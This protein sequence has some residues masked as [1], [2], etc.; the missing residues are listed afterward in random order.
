LE[1]FCWQACL[2]LRRLVSSRAVQ[3]GGADS[4]DDAE[5]ITK[6]S[7]EIEEDRDLVL[8]VE[9]A[10][11]PSTTY[12]EVTLT[13][14]NV[15]SSAESWWW[16]THDGTNWGTELEWQTGNG[17]AGIYKATVAVADYPD[18][19]YITGVAG[20]FT[21]KVT[22]VSDSSS[23]S[24]STDSADS[25]ST[26]SS[27]T[28]ST[29]STSTDSSSTDSS[30]SSS[31]SGTVLSTSI[32]ELWGAATQ[33]LLTADQISGYSKLTIS[34]TNNTLT[35]DTAW[36]FQLHSASFTS[37]DASNQIG[38]SWSSDTTQTVTL[39]SI[40][41]YTSGIY[42]TGTWGADSTAYSYTITVTAE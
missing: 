18:G 8:V 42:I 11:L 5:S 34:I 38:S 36:G 28:D 40:S 14:P 7:V 17:S 24:S 19:L 13:N 39:S 4:D 6:E 10:D 2:P 25:T 35:G 21:I 41:S 27:S 15:T 33:Q 37:W 22:G 31:A 9:A 29:D 32:T 12:M 16:G 26:D 20:T 23:S 1:K 3:G 30:S